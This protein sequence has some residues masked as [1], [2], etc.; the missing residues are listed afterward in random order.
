MPWTMFNFDGQ[1]KYLT[2]TETD[3]FLREAHKENPQTYAFCWILATTGCRIS[4]AL[5]LSARHIDFEAK[6]IIIESLKKRRKNV[7][8]AVPL[9]LKQLERLKHWIVD[10]TLGNERLWTWS[11][12]TAYRRVIEVMRKARIFGP[13]ATP[14][15]LRHG[16]GIR[17]VQSGIPLNLVQRW[18]GHA[19]MKTTAIYASAMGPEE[20]EI[21]ARMWLEHEIPQERKRPVLAIQ[22]ESDV[23]LRERIDKDINIE[24]DAIQEA[25][26]NID[27]RSPLPTIIP[28]LLNTLM[29]SRPTCKL[30]QFWLFC[31]S[32]FLYSSSTY[33]SGR[34]FRR[35][36]DS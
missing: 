22:R 33:L 31:N 36:S 35:D 5:S 3:N 25:S 14:K 2:R 30:I 32:D 8:R 34:A 15:G 21:A 11:R 7:F 1:R 18:L 4:E 6:H 28:K 24:N 19:D 23:L 17:A 20:R 13:W 16:F 27:K 26:H 12:M 29:E 10:G 9:P